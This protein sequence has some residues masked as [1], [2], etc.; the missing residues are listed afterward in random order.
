MIFVFGLH[1]DDTA[2]W[3][4]QRFVGCRDEVSVGYWVGINARSDQTGVVSH[5]DHEIR[6]NFFSDFGEAFEVDTQRVSRC[7]SD[8][9]FWFDSRAKRSIAS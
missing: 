7:T 4:A 6:A 9:Q 2:T 5:I 3:A 8:D 1:Q